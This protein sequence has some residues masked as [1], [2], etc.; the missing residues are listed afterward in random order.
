MQDLPTLEGQRKNC[1]KMLYKSVI[2]LPLLYFYW[3]IS[4]VFTL[5][6]C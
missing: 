6:M 1:R 5:Y 2:R 3:F 4:S